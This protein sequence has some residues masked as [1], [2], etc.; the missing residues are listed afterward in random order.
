MTK[1][2]CIVKAMNDKLAQDIVAINME[3]AS[4]LYDTFILCTASNK[5]LLNAIQD[6]VV[7]QCEKNGFEIKSIEG[8]GNA[9]WIL[10]D[11]GDV[12]CHIFSEKARKEYNLEK[13]WS[14]MP[15]IDIKE[16][17]A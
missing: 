3:N 4:P 12:I 15:T 6:N 10:I 16:Y 2:E 1:V 13:L 8:R 17:L 9:E 7:D 14:D 11:A 5:R